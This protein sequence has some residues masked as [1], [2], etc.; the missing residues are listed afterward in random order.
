MTKHFPLT[1]AERG[2]PDPLRNWRRY[3][4]L[5]AV[6]HARGGGGHN[7]QQVAR[8]LY[9][10]DFGAVLR[11][12]VTPTTLASASA[13]T[14]APVGAFLTELGPQSSGAQ[15]LARAI[16]VSLERA[17][18]ISLPRSSTD[19]TA[20]WVAEGAPMPVAMG[21][22]SSVTLTLKKLAVIMTMTN[23]L[24]SASA[25]SA[26]TIVRLIMNDAAGRAL[27]QAVF[28]TAAETPE[29]PAGLLAGVTAQ[30][31]TAGGGLNAL[32]GDLRNLVGAIHDGGGGSQI[33]LFAS[34]R[35]AAV[36]PLYADPSMLMGGVILAPSL[37]AGTVVAVDVG[38]IAATPPAVPEIESAPHATLNMEDVTPLAISTPGTPNVVAAPVRS[39]FQSDTIALRLILRMSWVKRSPSAVQFVTGATW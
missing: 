38:A 18:S 33:V 37:P 7:F 8:D 34:P 32:T 15:L 39:T 26:E 14:E 35:Q 11:A 28:G 19:V 2:A 36:L 5:R 13:L 12:A 1:M 31:A 4:A 17:R 10:D 30:T 27:D 3:L 20:A 29:R 21:G 9:G 25:E 23:E 6:A 24:A 16:N 22:F